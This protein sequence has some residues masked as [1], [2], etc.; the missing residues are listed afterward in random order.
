MW[1]KFGPRVTTSGESRE[2][3]AGAENEESHLPRDGIPAQSL[4][5][6]SGEGPSTPKLE[7]IL[8]GPKVLLVLPDGPIYS[9]RRGVQMAEV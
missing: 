9:L 5:G 6:G 1:F 7:W 3:L 8:V 4:T 2:L